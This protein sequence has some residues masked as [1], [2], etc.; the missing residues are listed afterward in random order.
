MI[1]AS[2]SV[3]EGETVTLIAASSGDEAGSVEFLAGRDGGALVPIATAPMSGGSAET[4]WTPGEGAAGEYEIVARL[5]SDLASDDKPYGSNITVVVVEE[6]EPDPDPPPGGGEGFM[7][8][9]NPWQGSIL[10]A[11]FGDCNATG[12][13]VTVE[14][15]ES[16]SGVLT[17]TLSGRSWDGDPDTIDNDFTGP[18]SASVSGQR[19]DGA[20]SFSLSGGLKGSFGGSLQINGASDL[21]QFQGTFENGDVCVDQ[22]GPVDSGLALLIGSVAA[23]DQ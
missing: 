17:G 16:D 19:S 7:G 21:W 9:N 2:G 1:A 23:S 20:V 12:F 14:F 18:I 22:I 15:D 10:W 3:E 4:D 6:P 11:S 13:L 5:R 8:R